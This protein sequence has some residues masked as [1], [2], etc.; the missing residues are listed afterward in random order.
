[1]KKVTIVWKDG[2]ED[3]IEDITAVT[4]SDKTLRL[5]SFFR[6][7]SVKPF[8]LSNIKSILIEEYTND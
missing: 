1:M 4:Y 8:K 3:V 5:K 6:T 7:V 2:K